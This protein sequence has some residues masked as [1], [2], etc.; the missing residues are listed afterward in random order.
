MF[1][2]YSLYHKFA[3][4]GPPF[5]CLWYPKGFAIEWPLPSKCPCLCHRRDFAIEVLLHSKCL[6]LC[7]EGLCHQRAFAHMPSKGYCLCLWRAFALEWPSPLLSKNVCL[8]S[9][10]AF[11]FAIEGPLHWKCLCLCHRRPLPMLSKSY[12]LC[13]WRAFALGWP[14]PLLPK[15]FCLRRDFAFGIEGLFPSKCPWLWHR[16][17]FCFKVPFP[18]KPSKGLFPWSQR[19]TYNASN[20]SM[21]SL[22]FATEGTL[23]HWRAFVIEGPL[24]L[25]SFCFRMTFAFA[26]QG[27]D[28]MESFQPELHEFLQGKVPSKVKAR[29]L[30]RQRPFD[31]KGPSIATCKGTSMANARALWRQ[32]G[33]SMAKE[34][35]FCWQ[36]PFEGKDISKAKAVRRQNVNCTDCNKRTSSLLTISRVLTAGSEI[37]HY[38]RVYVGGCCSSLIRCMWSIGF[39]EKALGKQRQGRFEAKGPSMGKA[40]AV[41]RQRLVES[42]DEG[43]SKARLITRDSIQ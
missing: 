33:P 26:F 3:F 41:R 42:K 25:K 37:L 21:T 30:W 1:A 23:P 19:S 14:S 34:R 22:A 7:H 16:R 10:F 40:K 15:S 32:K 18:S 27:A 13:F 2:C 4:E 12:C 5:P 8:R 36:R 35:A 20:Y 28:Y 17:A 6:C 24:P 31:G 11:A 9:T 29:A 39:K 38:Q 43:H